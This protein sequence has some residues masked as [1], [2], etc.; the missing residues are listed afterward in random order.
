MLNR[1]LASCVLLAG[2]IA[3][4]ACGD[5][6]T[7]TPATQS[8]GREPVKVGLLLPGPAADRG[9]K[10]LASDSLATLAKDKSIEPITRQNVKKDEAADA[11][12][13]FESRGVALVIAHGY[14]YLDAAKAL[15]DPKNPN[16][17]KVKI[18]VSGGDVDDP[19]F[20]SLLYDLGPA[21]YQLGIVAGKTT[22]S[23]KLGFIGGD[24]FPTVTVMARG[25]EAGAKSVNP[26]VAVTVVYTNNWD[27]PAK[28]KQAAEGLI[29]QGIDV[30]MQN[31]DAASSGVFEAVK[32]VNA[33]QGNPATYTFGAN[34]DQNANTICPDFTLGSAVIKMD[35]AFA[36][37]VDQIKAGTFKGGLVKEDLAN[38]VAVAVLN[39]NLSGKVITAET[40]Q[41]VD[42]A[43]K[44]LTDGK[45]K[46]PEK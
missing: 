22:K 23:N 6:G 8:S 46:I 38:G 21:S 45:V 30:I 24:P 11:I 43:G 40:Q 16:A 18:V 32:A 28:A 15:T 31:V 19:N 5:S 13:Q 20:Q 9:W 10:Q 12:R 1:L 14:E 3:I 33:R 27:D 34:S 4:A 25:F 36:R 39:P 26:N 29:N 2:A 7:T 42:R 37:V 35:T 17:T 44:D 41:L